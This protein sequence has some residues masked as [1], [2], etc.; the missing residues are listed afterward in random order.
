[1]TKKR[2]LTGDRASGSLHLGHYVGSIVNRLKLQE[3]YDCYYMVADYHA[4]TTLYDHPGEVRESTRSIFVDYLAVGL[5]PERSTLFVQSM[6]PQHSELNLLFQMLV[7]IAR[8]ERIPTLKDKLDDLHL[9]E[10]QVSLGLLGYPVLQAADILVYK[11]DLVPVGDDQLSHLELTREIA[12]RFNYLYGPTFPEPEALLSQ[13]SRLPG[14]DGRKKMSK[15][16]GNDIALHHTGEEVQ[17]RVRSMVTDPSKVR[18]TDPGHPEICTVFAFHK[19]F[20]PDHAEEVATA[21][22]AGQLGCVEDK[23][24]LATCLNSFLEP[25]RLRRAGLLAH[26]QKLAETLAFGV[27]KARRVASQTLAEV[28]E[29]M[30]LG[31]MLF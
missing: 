15:S 19:A 1:M 6:V 17:E 10:G 23:R 2:I 30:Q 22:R 18:K 4:Y 7:T 26:P 24:N 12:R 21:C 29:K 25:I 27:E 16:L 14:L 11:A 5:D 28:R 3:E 13:T 31:Y 9:E 20:N 8:A